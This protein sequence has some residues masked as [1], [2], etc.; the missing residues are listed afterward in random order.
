MISET[1]A[2]LAAALTRVTVR[3]AVT[4]AAVGVFLAMAFGYGDGEHNLDAAEKFALLT[5]GFYFGAQSARTK[6]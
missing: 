2:T 4:V 6:D 1:Q 5:A 3:A